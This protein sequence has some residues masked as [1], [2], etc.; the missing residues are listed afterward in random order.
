[1][2]LGMVHVERREM[3]QGRS[4]LEEGL[5]LAEALG[6]SNLL[7]KAL[8]NLG[9]LE[10]REGNHARA[11]RCWRRAWRYASDAARGIPY[12]PI[13]VDRHLSDNV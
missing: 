3:N 5:A 7:A 9:V 11:R 4:L 10:I 1:M 12:F 13:P 6:N 2:L 8:K